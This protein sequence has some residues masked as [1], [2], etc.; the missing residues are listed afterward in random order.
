MILKLYI[1]LFRVITVNEPGNR[2]KHISF[3]DNII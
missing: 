1:T 3:N 2:N